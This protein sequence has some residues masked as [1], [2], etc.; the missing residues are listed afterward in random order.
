MIKRES[1]KLPDPSEWTCSHRH[2]GLTHPNCFRT[3]LEQ[4]PYGAKIGY[5][6]IETTN[7]DADFG[8]IICWSILDRDTDT[9]VS[10]CITDKDIKKAQKA[11]DKTTKA[12]IDER[13]V[14]TLTKELYK[15]DIIY[16]YYGSRFDLKFIRTRDLKY[17]IFY[18]PHQTLM[19]VDLYFVARS[20]LKLHSNRLESVATYFGFNTKT[21]L[22][23]DMWIM[24]LVSKKARDYILEHNKQDVKMLKKVHQ[25]LQPYIAGK[26]SS[27]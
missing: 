17:Q 6:D 19:H 23:P 11:F 3:Y 10:D 2:N 21:Q 16:T 20:K 22:L 26:R 25:L 7:L 1:V 8:T 15:Y 5:L 14:S 18:P 13:V 27:L 24:S 4:F 9:I 12:N